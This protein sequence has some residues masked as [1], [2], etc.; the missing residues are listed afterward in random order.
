MN[1]FFMGLILS[2]LVSG[3]AW[4]GCDPCLCG[5]GGGLPPPKGCG[6]GPWAGQL[7]PDADVAK[8]KAILSQEAVQTQLAED[9][10]L[11]SVER[12]EVNGDV[13]Y[14]FTTG[15]GNCYSANK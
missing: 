12:V 4:A 13:N 14:Q 10:G 11:V 7:V 6:Y 2:I 8:L 9:G 3:S 15:Q 5:Y 1:K